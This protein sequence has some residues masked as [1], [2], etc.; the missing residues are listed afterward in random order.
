M[1]EIRG[2]LPTDARSDLWVARLRISFASISTRVPWHNQHL[3]FFIGLAAPCMNWGAY[4]LCLCGTNLGLLRA[5]STGHLWHI[6]TLGIVSWACCRLIIRSSHSANVTETIL[7]AWVLQW[8]ISAS[9]RRRCVVLMWA[10][11]GRL[12]LILVVLE[13]DG[14]W[15]LSLCHGFI[16][17]FGQLHASSQRCDRL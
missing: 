1:F 3:V 15:I 5:I 11:H 16:L 4:V 7:Y 6:D 17:F 9:C 12:W 2:L 14:K 8:L 10:S 13:G